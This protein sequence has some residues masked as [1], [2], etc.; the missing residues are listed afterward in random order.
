MGLGATA[1]SGK[2]TNFCRYGGQN[3]KKIYAERKKRI[4]AGLFIH[5]AVDIELVEEE[6]DVELH[7]DCGAVVAA[8]GD[9]GIFRKVPALSLKRIAFFSRLAGR[10]LP[11]GR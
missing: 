6:L 2:D 8:S 11:V 3:V 9:Q 5:D 4:G 1:W 7:E 10:R